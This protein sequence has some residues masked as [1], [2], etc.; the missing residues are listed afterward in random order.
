MNAHELNQRLCDQIEVVLK[1][2]FPNGRR[3]RAEFCVG[4]LGGEAGDSLKVHLGGAKKGHWQDFATGA[5][6]RTLLGLWA[7]VLGGDYARACKEARGFLGISDDYGKRF[8][9]EQAPKPSANVDRGKL[10]V[11]KPG[12]AVAAYLMEERKLDLGIVVAYLVA[13]SADGGAVAFPFFAV[14]GEEGDTRLAESAYMVKFLKLARDGGKKE[15]WTQPAGVTDS[16]FG[17]RAALPFGA[18]GLYPKGVLVITEGE[19][20]AM[21]VAT[22][23][24]HGVSVPR[25]AKA[26]GADGKSANDQWIEADYEWLANFERIYLWLDADEPGQKAARDIAQRIGLERCYIVTTPRGL[27]DA[28]DCLCAGVPRE[29]IAQAFDQAATLDPANLVWASEFEDKVFRRLFPPGGVEPGLDLP[30]MLPWKIRPGEM[31]VWT[32]FSKHGKTVLLSHLMVHLANE[33]QRICVA[34]MEVEPDKTLETYWCQANGGR[35]PWSWE[36]G[37]GIPDVDRERIGEARFRER[38]SWLAERVLV[39][40]PETGTG[41]GRADWRKLVECFV[42]ARQRYGCEQFVVDSLMMCVGR[43]ETEYQQV[44]LFV[45]ALSNFAK[46]HQV[47]V[48]LVAHSRKKDDETKPPGKQDIAG[49][50][51]TADIAHNVCVVQRNAKKAM[52]WT[53]LERDLKALEDMP[54]LAEA[55]LE[56]DRQADIA[57]TKKELSVVKGWHD[58]ELHLLGQRNGDGDVG[59]KYLYYLT[60]ARQFVESSPWSPTRTPGSYPRRYIPVPEA[61]PTTEE[62]KAK[63]KDG[64]QPNQRTK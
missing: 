10:R 17:K 15:I 21:S 30:W 61:L 3:V 55:G 50:K 54:P 22:Y 18:A 20:D 24:W 40:L 31:T 6:S 19:I 47:H 2:L 44:E 53:Q 64:K 57:N 9:R 39:F 59:S 46:R 42:Y 7:E 63:P 48:H 8:Y 38:F 23:G 5:K 45:N 13:E 1:H 62:L 58:G 34:S 14:E 12:G 32:G 60:N 28:N 41:V 27:K 43:S 37:Q 4:G 36:E 25:G 56:A 29:E 16:L 52:K 33:G 49:P 26:A 11:L 51:E 35:M